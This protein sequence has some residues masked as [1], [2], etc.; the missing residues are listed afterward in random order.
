MLNFFRGSGVGKSIVAAVVFAVIIVFVIE[1]RAGSNRGGSK[2]TRECAVSVHG[3]CVEQKEF[4]A[5]VGLITPQGIPAKA[6]RE[7]KLRHQILQGLVERELLVKAAED[8]GISVSEKE[9]DE[10][11][12]AGRAHVSLPAAMSK[13][14]IGFDE[15]LVRPLPVK[16]SQTKEFDYKIYERAVRNITNRSPREFKEMQKR[17]L[18]AARMRALV[19]SRVRISEAEAFESFQRERSKAVIRSVE[20]KRDWFAKYA[21]DLSTAAVDAWLEENKAQVD[22]AWK[23]EQT[24]FTAGCQLVSEIVVNAGEGATDTDKTL[25]RDRIESAR[26]RLEQGESFADVAKAISDGPAA[27]F[28]GELGCLTEASRPEAKELLETVKALKPGARSDVI[29]TTAGFHIVKLDGVLDEASR[30]KLGRRVIGKK[31]A[32]RFK[33]D[34][35]AKQF[36]VELIERVKGGAKLDEA[37]LALTKSYLAAAGKPA[38]GEEDPALED[39]ARPK[40]EISAPFGPSGSP[41]FSAMENVAALAFNLQ[42]PDDVHDKPI[43]TRS[44]FLVVQL[45][46][47]ELA[48]REDF[49][50]DRAELLRK[51]R[52]AKE[53]DAEVRYLAEL[54]RA[55]QGKIKV[56]ESLAEEPK[57]GAEGEM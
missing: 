19:R 45:K 42:K 49:D 35:R 25:G 29:E 39:P 24:N 1:F 7:Y 9:I 4:F 5:A 23:A 32:G 38:K 14:V 37:T 21:V 33:A 47:K 53:Q 55:G 30:E 8:L 40:V 36:A 17:E 6:L 44:G 22:E 16:S 12:A 10:E 27:V 51:L 3:E 15:Q 11:L 56:D 18:I 50:K 57:G 34:E 28:G 43:T 46:E 48:R 52:S 26:K 41:F 13:Q 31:L 2:L 20:T 54:R